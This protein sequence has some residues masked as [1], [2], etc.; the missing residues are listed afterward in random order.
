MQ[1]HLEIPRDIALRDMELWNWKEASAL[2]KGMTHA[3]PSF[4]DRVIESKGE[5]GHD[6]HK[7]KDW[8][9]AFPGQ[10]NKSTE[11]WSQCCLPLTPSTGSVV[12]MLY[13]HFV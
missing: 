8:V 10:Q 6:L 3:N 13:L 1:N 7:S 12:W 5:A 4:M 9:P 2:G 11:N